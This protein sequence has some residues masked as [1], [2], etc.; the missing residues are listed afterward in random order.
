MRNDI[1]IEILTEISVYRFSMA[2]ADALRGM[3]MPEFGGGGRRRGVS[4]GAGPQFLP[5]MVT[6]MRSSFHSCQVLSMPW[7]VD[8][9]RNLHRNPNGEL[10]SP[11]FN[12]GDR[13]AK[14]YTYAGVRRGGG[15]EVTVL[16]RCHSSNMTRRR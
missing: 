3:R 9:E 8:V 2:V 14:R 5:G 1:C 6:V 10:C 16:V 12:G 7:F 15:E 4:F 11:F 13:C